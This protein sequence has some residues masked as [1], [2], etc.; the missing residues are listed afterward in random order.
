M[1]EKFRSLW[2]DTEELT[3]F[4]SLDRD[5]IA[6]VLVIGGGMAGI[7]CAYSLTRA[8]AD[9]ILVEADRLCGGIT[10]NTTAKITSQ[11]GL[12][13]HTLIKRFGEE[14]ARLYLKANEDA[15]NAYRSLSHE[16]DCEFSEKSAFAYSLNDPN[17]I[18]EELKALSHIGFRAKRA[19]NLPL[20]FPVAG[21]VEFPNQA[22]FHPLKFIAAL[23]PG[24]RIFEHT[25]V[26]ELGKGFAKT[27][28]GTI[29]ANK[30]IVATHFPFLNKH[31]LYFLKQYQDRSYVIALKNAPDL[32]GMYIDGEAGGMSFRN[33]EGLLLIGGG[34]HRTGKSGVNRRELE[35][36]AKRY[37]PESEIVYRWAT[38][39]CMTL[40]GIPYIGQYSASTPDLFVATGFNKW[41]MTSSMV[42]ASV[43]TDLVQGKI[44]TYSELFSPSRS[45]M[46]PQLAIN[47]AEATVNLLTP[48][49][50]RCPHLG[51]ALKWNPEEN[52]WDC[53]C[54][55]SRFDSDGNLIDGP[56]TDDIKSKK[57]G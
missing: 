8:G 23:L 27:H 26:L 43:L 37:Y 46:R 29:K 7:L 39:D 14:K 54:H 51:C 13:Y 22:Q 24:I 34:G 2:A 41:G 18:E 44:N 36:F 48:S 35:A 56:A 33:A 4:G 30:I 49:K 21:A 9:C 38:Q 52:S 47:F 42:A 53:P 55:G 3:H 28:K 16:A 12:I 50:K 40:D 6:D 10:E 45:I 19:V 25:K 32:G 57:K 17:V 20:P 15:L 1:A 31:G 11:H 5:I